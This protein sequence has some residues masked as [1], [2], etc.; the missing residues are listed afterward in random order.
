MSRSSIVRDVVCRD[1]TTFVSHRAERNRSRTRLSKNFLTKP[2]LIALLMCVV[3]FVLQA[4]YLHVTVAFTDEG[5]YIEAGRM[6]LDGL[7][8]YVDFKFYHMPLL[9]AV[10]GIGLKVGSPLY[11]LRILYLALGI[12]A[13]YLLFEILRRRSGDEIAALVAL[14]FYLTLFKCTA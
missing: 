8:P 9:P 5:A 3:G 12:A 13:A 4:R 14:F 7:M 1:L 2:R 11:L 6:M 10:I